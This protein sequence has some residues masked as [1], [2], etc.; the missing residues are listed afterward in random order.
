MTMEMEYPNP[1][2]IQKNLDGLAKKV[3]FNLD[4]K[5]L[6][7]QT[8]Q[9]KQGT[10]SDRGALC[11]ETGKF[12]GRSPKDRFIVKDDSTSKII[13]WGEINIPISP[14][15][16]DN[17]YEKML[18]FLSGKDVW[19][20]QCFAGADP[21]Y[22][23]G[24]TAINTTPWANLFCH[25]LFIRPNQTELRDYKED[26]T[27]LQIPEFLAN[28][29]V[30]GTRQE[31]FS[32]INFT[33]KIILIGGTA[34][35]GEMKKGIF[36]VLN[37][38]LPYEKNVLPMHCSANEGDEGDVALFFGLSG[39]GKTTLS[40]DANR[41]LIGDDEHGWADNTVFNFEGGC[42]AKCIDL[43]EEKEPEIY[44]AIKSH[45][46]LENTL[47]HKDSNIVDFNNSSITENTRA[48]YPIHYIL[49]SKPQSIGDTPKNIFFLTCDAYGI[50]PPISKL[51]KAQ[52]MYHFI[53][54]YTA[55][56][57]GTEVGVTEPQTTFS[58]C[59]GRV[60]LPDNPIRYAELLGEKLAKHTEVNVWLVNTGWTGG[61]YGT[62]KRISLK[63]T[64]C[65]VQAAISGALNN[66]DYIPHH[67]FGILVPQTCP[68]VP[69][70]LL[71]PQKTWNSSKAYDRE[72]S[73]LAKQ[74]IENFRQYENRA[75]LEIKSA[76]PRS[77]NV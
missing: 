46:L 70:E 8:V 9:L 29:E 60:F 21:A 27:I 3:Y 28:P 67:I 55:K 31:N 37:F 25:H 22:R 13:D 74:F 41:K 19:I 59:F 39:T 6:V 40:A 24:V 75:N 30:D 65:L 64:R 76:S 20:R 68:N 2:S 54:G 48:A 50:L 43:S 33:K 66:V 35:T 72:A 71:N 23:I 47:F 56:V 62:G 18:T 45:T 51:T 17:L 57:A 16:F 38:I 15:I 77:S 69:A 26:W 63:H 12:T 49:N 1:V 73:K 61:A 53:S 36:S 58:A 44:A 10:I 7:E 11:I 32:I 42:Y 5:T 52:A 34:Y 14:N 4:A